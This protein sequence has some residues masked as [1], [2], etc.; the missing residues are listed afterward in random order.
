MR[1]KGIK[2]A[3]LHFSVDE[4]S[5]TRTEKLKTQPG[6]RVEKENFSLVPTELITHV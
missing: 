1:T 2:T 5:C 6:N 3:A 4:A